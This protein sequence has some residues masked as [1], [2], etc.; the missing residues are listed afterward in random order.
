MGA[1]FGQAVIYIRAQCLQWHPAFAHFF[2]PRNFS[3][4]ETSRTDNANTLRACLHCPEYRLFHRPAMGNP[5]FQ[6]VAY[7]PRHQ[8]SVQ[9]SLRD[10]AHIHTNFPAQRGFQKRLGFIHPLSAATNHNTWPRSMHG[11]RYFVIRQAFDLYL[12]HAGVGIALRY[13]FAQF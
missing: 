8:I 11:D 4:A 6:L 10:F 3:A 5:A 12:G 2:P 1:R 7:R 13:Y 9:F